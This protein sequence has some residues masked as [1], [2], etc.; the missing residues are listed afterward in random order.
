MIHSVLGLLFINLLLIKNNRGFNLQIST[1]STPLVININIRSY[2]F[3]SLSDSFYPLSGSFSLNFKCSSSKRLFIKKLLY[4]PKRGH[5]A[6]FIT[7]VR[8][9][10]ECHGTRSYASIR[11]AGPL[12]GENCKI[13]CSKRQIQSN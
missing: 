13:R 3:K 2:S 6:H 1:K 5:Q 7:V 8:V 12:K 11:L 10:P 4:T 9:G